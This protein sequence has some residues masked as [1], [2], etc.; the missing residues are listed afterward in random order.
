V[1]LV[2]SPWVEILLS[3]QDRMT[4]FRSKAEN[5]G[6]ISPNWNFLASPIAFREEGF[7]QLVAQLAV[8]ESL[9][10]D[11]P[12]R[13]FK[14]SQRQFSESLG[15]DKHIADFLE[16]ID[17]VPVKPPLRWDLVPSIEG[18]KILE[19][20]AG[21]CLGG[22]NGYPLYLC[23]S[24]L[25]NLSNNKVSDHFPNAIAF[26]S[27]RILRNIVQDEKLKLFVA[28]TKQYYSDYEFFLNSIVDDLNR[29]NL[30][31]V[32]AIKSCDIEDN[33]AYLLPMFTVEELLDTNNEHQRL[34]D[35]LIAGNI[36]SLIPFSEFVYSNKGVLAL[37]WDQSNWKMFSDSEISVIKSLI[38]KS[39]FL[40]SEDHDLLA[41]AFVVKPSA[42]YGGSGVYC[43]WE[44]DEASLMLLVEKSVAANEIYIV[45]E[46]VS[47]EKLKAIT[48]DTNNNVE[49]GF[50]YPVLGLITI[51]SEPVGG[52]ARV[53]LNHDSPGTINAH[54]G[55]ALGLATQ[56]IKYHMEMSK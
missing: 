16:L 27:R 48:V 41:T 55:A 8:L 33:R 12:N 30:L 1:R 42:G 22:F 46:K 9:I 3:Q 31:P 32:Q 35:G 18:W 50:G 11:L 13:L 49:I 38:P 17:E 23:Y 29:I 47:G 36:K 44:Y 24:K 54:K 20:N 14:G 52:L 45:Q 7:D 10:F 34:V 19:L 28:E 6:L 2:E 56:P 26:Y 15:I 53:I 5:C 37:L 25:A 4:D 51:N 43:S 40:E 39:Y 21:A